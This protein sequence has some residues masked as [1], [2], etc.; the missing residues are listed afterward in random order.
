MHIAAGVTF[1]IKGIVQSFRNGIFVHNP[2][3][4][5]G[6]GGGFISMGFFCDME[7]HA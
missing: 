1:V 5:S 7:H 6:G 4:F 2:G 3:V